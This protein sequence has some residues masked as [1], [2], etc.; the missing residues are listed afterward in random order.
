MTTLTGPGPAESTAEFPAPVRAAVLTTGLGPVAVRGVAALVP[1]A[2]ITDPAGLLEPGAPTEFEPI[3]YLGKKGLRYKDRATLLGSAAALLALAEAGGEPDPRTG[4]IVASCYGNLDTVCRVAEQIE[5]GGVPATSP[6]DLPNA[7]SNVIA[8]TIAIRA[9]FHGVCLSV[10][11]GPDSG[12]AAL[13]WA[14]RL[15]AAGRAG[16]VLVVGVETPSGYERGLR[17]PGALPLVDGAV[18]V[19]LGAAGP[20][21]AGPAAGRV[22]ATTPAG[23]VLPGGH[24]AAVAG[25]ADLVAA[26]HRVSTGAGP[27]ALAAGRD[28]WSVSGAGGAG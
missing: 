2:G 18:A 11:N 26:V 5:T 1:S 25:V 14:Q 6:M 21:S 3:R 12:W 27:L 20:D 13:L 24:L 7:S 28:S 8:A 23:P 9:G 16:T 17:G 10:C 19:V 4:V 22:P 15:L